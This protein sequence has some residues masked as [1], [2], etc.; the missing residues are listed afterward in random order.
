M[1]YSPGYGAEKGFKGDGDYSDTRGIDYEAI[2][3]Y[4]GSDAFILLREKKEFIFVAKNEGDENFIVGNIKKVNN[5]KV[6]FMA[7]GVVFV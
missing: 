5:M 3:F 7:F 1:C 2:V 6:K 4:D